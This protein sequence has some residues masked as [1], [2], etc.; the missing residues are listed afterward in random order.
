MGGANSMSKRN[1]PAPPPRMSES[2]LSVAGASS[3]ISPK[4]MSETDS[5]MAESEI[6]G[7][8]GD[9]LQEMDE[10]D[11]EYYYDEDGDGAET[12][13][14]VGFLSVEDAKASN[15]K[16]KE[17]LVSEADF[18]AVFGMAKEAFYGQPMWK[19]TQQKKKNGFF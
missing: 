19:Q 12:T 16:N 2:H 17:S 4:S 5:A 13:A 7:E 14:E 10:E 8:G 18:E 3:F 6:A 9:A 15:E 11:Y 1:K